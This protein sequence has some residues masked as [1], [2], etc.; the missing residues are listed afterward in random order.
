MFTLIPFHEF[1]IRKV[2]I[3]LLLLLAFC[4]PQLWAFAAPLQ[5]QE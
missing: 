4:G 1:T 3:S 5:D 2:Q